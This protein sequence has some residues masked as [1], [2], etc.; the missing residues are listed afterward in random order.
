MELLRGHLSLRQCGRSIWYPP[1]Y[2]SASRRLGLCNT[3]GRVAGRIS[4]E[5]ST[6]SGDLSALHAELLREIDERKRSQQQ[7]L[8]KLNRLTEQEA[9]L[10][11]VG[12][13]QADQAPAPTQPREPQ[14]QQQQQQ[15]Q[16]QSARYV[17]NTSHSASPQ[18]TGYSSPRPV[19]QPAYVPP[20]YMPLP[21]VSPPPPSAP[22]HTP[23]SPTSLSFLPDVQPEPVALTPET[24]AASPPEPAPPPP[25]AG[26]NVMNVVMV[27]AECAPWSKTGGLGDVMSALPK[28]M[29]RRGHRV[30]VV[31]PRYDN[32]LD[33]W[34]TGVRIKFNCFGNE[35]EVGFFHAYRDGVDYVFV[36]HACFNTRGKDIYGGS[37]EELLF[38]CS[39]LSKAA[40]E[41]VWHVPC[42]GVTYGDTN[43][44][45]IANDWHTALLPVYLQAHYRDYGKMTYARCVFVIHNM[46]HQGRG[47]FA[48][49]AFLELNDTYK[50]MFRLYDPVGGEHMNI[51]KVGLQTSHRLVAVSHGYAWECLTPEGGWGLHTILGEAKWK[52][53]GIVNG[54]DTQEWNP[55]NDVHLQGDGYTNYSMAD[56][57]EGK[58]RCKMA[59]QAEL[60]LPV[61]PDIPMLGFIG[62][63]DYQKG[64]DLIRDNYDWL[65]SEKVQLVLLGSGRDDLEAALRDMEARNKDQC[66]GWVGFS[67]KM[68]HRI[69][70]GC[71]VLLMPSRFE[72]CGLNQLYAMAYG[73]VPV[74]HAVGGLRDTVTPY[75]P[76]DN[77][78]T[79]W[80]FDSADASKLRGSIGDALFTYRQYRQS[81]NSIAL[82]GM[83]Q[84]LS[85]DKAAAQYEEVLVAAKFQW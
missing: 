85:W 70:A 46:A 20:T 10:K 57:V 42:G 25:L 40:I 39:M 22:T 11:S 26:P 74:V 48:E 18:P 81:F 32:Y 54:I 13:P 50:E 3:G 28:A 44:A 76:F 36:D 49:T 60:G 75:H 47:P 51:M 7:L 56:L 43:L 78:G 77:T 45:F 27:G 14:Q 12:T 59:L 83:E 73:T 61:S 5:P 24:V 6:S 71:D 64:V 8:A 16:Q 30:M 68:A 52:L 67:V 62:R 1:A 53:R 41:A 19:S 66:R 65:M 72:P 31:A 15:P 58:R 80:V 55:V 9:R 34:E 35:Q 37:R 84:D 82:R 69:T 63:L 79:G 29:Q 17:A 2:P 33:A 21:R 4:A 38:R 23:S